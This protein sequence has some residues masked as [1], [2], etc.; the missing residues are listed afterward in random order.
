MRAPLCQPFAMLKLCRSCR[1][2]KRGEAAAS[3]GASLYPSAA[4]PAEWLELIVRSFGCGLP[5]SPA[6]PRLGL[7]QGWWRLRWVAVGSLAPGAVRS[8]EAVALGDAALPFRS[9]APLLSSSLTAFGQCHSSAPLSAPGLR[10]PGFQ[11]RPRK[12]PLGV[13]TDAMSHTSRRVLGGTFLSQFLLCSLR[14]THHILGAGVQP[15]TASERTVSSC[16]AAPPLS[17]LPH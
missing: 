4:Y 14:R 6:C 3:T 2:Q 8:T 13:T 1:A 5:P 11:H 9:R 15:G 7:F 10:V 16:P 17:A 12:E